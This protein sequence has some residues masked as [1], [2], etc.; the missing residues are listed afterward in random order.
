MADEP[1]RCGCCEADVPPS[2]GCTTRR[3]SRRLPTASSMHG[4]FL[5]RMLSQL[6]RESIED[7]PNVLRY[8]LSQ[9][10]DTQHRRS[11]NRLLDAWALVA[12][13]LTFYQER[14]ANE[15]YL[16]TATERRSILELAAL[17]GYQLN[18]GVAA[19]A[20]LAFQVDDAVGAPASAIV[21]KGMRVQSVPGQDELPQPFETSEEITARVEWNALRPAPDAAAG[22]GDQRRQAGDARP[23]R[24]HRSG[25]RSC[26]TRP[27][28]IR[29]ISICPFRLPATIEVRGSEH[30]LRRGNEH[31]HQDRR[32][33]TAG[34]QKECGR[35]EGA[36][37]S[38]SRAGGGGAGRAE[39]DARRF[40]R[41]AG[42]AARLRHQ[43]QSVSPMYRCSRSGSTR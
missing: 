4:G 22:V 43:A 35:C 39:S 24:R 37:A 3:A 7:A 32:R 12:D 11:G 27:R 34:R 13:V 28:C 19:S 16:R 18:P 1:D 25:R 41:A 38:Q 40:R 36:D 15:G 14:I 6:S 23:E 20:H 10:G 29:S 17:I 31:Q 21:P 26:R 9:A 33:R 8:P 2:R 30:D 42:Q 5:R